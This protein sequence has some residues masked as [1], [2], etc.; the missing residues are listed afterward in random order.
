[1]GTWMRAVLPVDRG[2]TAKYASVAVAEL[3]EGMTAGGIRPGTINTL[4]PAMPA[5]FV[6]QE[7]GHMLPNFGSLFDYLDSDLALCMP[8]AVVLADWPAF[9]WGQLG[10]GPTA[11]SIAAL[12]SIGVDAAS[13]V[14]LVDMVFHLDSSS[15]PMLLAD[16][17]LRPLV[18][19]SFAALLMYHRERLASGEMRQVCNRLEAC[20]RQWLAG[21][22][23]QVSAREVVFQWGDL[24]S[25][26]FKGDNVHLVAR[27]ADSGSVQLA[28]VCATSTPETRLSFLR[29]V[30][31]TC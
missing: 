9:P 11:P 24:I 22:A 26:K 21:S 13:L 12:E 10:H 8:A 30:R 27:S 31:T 14:G 1:M 7:T 2:G 18:H 4:C 20:V 25:A 19:A 23:S 16:G 3:P 29:H 15:P 28:E 17:R 6:V 5:E